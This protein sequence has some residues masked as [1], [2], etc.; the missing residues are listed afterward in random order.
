MNIYR[1]NLLS[2]ALF[3]SSIPLACSVR[4]K[5]FDFLAEKNKDRRLDENARY[6]L[7]L[8]TLDVMDSFYR[9]M[10]LQFWR[11]PYQQIDFEKRITNIVYWLDLAIRNNRS[12]YAV[13]PVWVISQIMAESLFCELAISNSLAVGICQLMPRTASKGHNM[14]VAG[15]EKRHHHPPYVALQLADSL[16][17]Y[18]R[19]I[20]EKNRYL[21]ASAGDVKINLNKALQLL[22]EG[23]DAR[24]EAQAQINRNATLLEFDAKIK[25]AKQDYIEYI[26][27]NVEILG[28]RDIFNNVD[29][30]VGFDERF[31]YKKPI[32]AMVS[33][34]ANALRVRNGNILTAAAAYNAGLSRTWTDEALYTR[35]GKIP[36]FSETSQYLSRIIANYEEIAARFYA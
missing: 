21:K 12:V 35:Y 26:N 33:M 36:N 11:Q 23:Q 22:A 5:P 27:T 9:G 7:V 30:F 14:I 10:T 19:L 16:A 20:G 6:K 28:K 34:L 2:K 25:K 1:R 29:F 24:V 18:Q 4:A 13:D 31:T 3:A 8:A 17:R 32:F 15:K